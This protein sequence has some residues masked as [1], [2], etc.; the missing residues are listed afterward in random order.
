M[1]WSAD[2]RAIY[3]LHSAN[4]W[5]SY[6]DTWDESQ[7]QS[8][9]SLIPPA[10]LQQPI[11]GFGKVWREQLGGAEASIGWAKEA[12]RSETITRQYFEKGQMMVGSD[13]VILVLHADGTWEE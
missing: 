11:R 3:V 10:D 8:D 5:A 6:N 1:I 13:G 12:E 7:A 4:T 2:E 9:P